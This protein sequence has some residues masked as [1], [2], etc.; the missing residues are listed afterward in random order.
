MKQGVKSIS[1]RGR[2]L[3]TFMSVQTC[4]AQ[5]FRFRAAGRQSMP[6]ADATLRPEV[7]A[8]FSSLFSPDFPRHSEYLQKSDGS[9]QHLTQIRDLGVLPEKAIPLITVV[10]NEMPRLPDFLRHYRELGIQRFVI[11]DHCSNDGTLSYLQSQSD[12]QLYYAQSGYD[13]ALSG[14]MWVTGLARRFAMGRW[15]L[16]VD[17]DE[18]LVYQGMEE[19]GI[20]DLCEI[21]DKEGLTRLYA[22]MIDMYS[23]EPVVCAKVGQGK[24]LLDIAPY[25]DPMKH[26]DTVY[27]EHV[28]LPGRNGLYCY[29][30]S[31]T[32]GNLGIPSANGQLVGFHMEKFPLTKWH[33]RTAYCLVH[34]PFPLDENPRR[35]RGALLHF[36][37]VGNFV[38]YN[39]S[40]AEL[41]EAWDGGPHH[42]AYVETIS[43]NPNVTL[44]HPDSCF[45]EGPHSLISQGLMTPVNWR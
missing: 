4:V 12:V 19:H 31:R 24:R 5:A 41:A 17:A 32:F 36:R 16:H 6:S 20:S 3:R 21:L 39:Q 7:D 45:Y 18:L 11:V 13:K 26:G 29:T 34:C 43:K 23:R 8:W 14:Q 42:F 40:V 2:L 35:P 37:F 28:D 38:E 15:A 1:V 33:S 30:R 9:L 10:H 22:P 44:Y 27:Y 25:F